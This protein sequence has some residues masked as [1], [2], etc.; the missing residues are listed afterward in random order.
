MENG[1]LKHITD[2]FRAGL[3]LD[4]GDAEKLMDTLLE[5]RDPGPIAALLSAWNDK[6]ITED[7]LFALASL[8]RSRMKR[9]ISDHKT[10]VDMVGTGGSKVKTFN[11]STASAFVTAGA[12]VPTAKHGNRAATST[13]GSADVM[14]ELGI[15]VDADEFASER[16]LNENGICFMFAPRFHSLSPTLAAARRSLKRPTIFNALGPLCNP[17]KAPHH[18][19]GVWSPE[20][21]EIV[22]KVLGR[23]GAGKSWVVHAESGLDEISIEG[24]TGVVEISDGDTSYREVALEDFAAGPSLGGGLPARLNAVESAGLIRNILNNEMRNSDAERLVCVNAAAAIFV[25]GAAGDLTTAYEKALESIRSGAA[26]AK[27]RS[28]ARDHT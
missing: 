3:E 23:L 7:E 17:A 28:L 27:L 6:G 9:V 25:A 24:R 10:F 4:V 14:A 22:A 11:V 13:S 18:V 8:M 5:C 15:D 19:I 12:G 26:G 21:T 16:N 2:E 20:M 1:Y